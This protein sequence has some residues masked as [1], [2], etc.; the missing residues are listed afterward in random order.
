MSKQARLFDKRV[1]DR[2]IDKGLITQTD[3]AE[4]LAG[5]PDV[6]SQ[7]EPL[8]VDS[9]DSDDADDAPAESNSESSYNFDAPENDGPKNVYDF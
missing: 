5:L 6:E 3:V 9:D 7:S 4:Y 1:V 8:M 2:N